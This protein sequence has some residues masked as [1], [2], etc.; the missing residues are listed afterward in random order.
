MGGLY[1]G[2]ALITIATAFLNKCLG[3]V[4]EEPP[5]GRHT[6]TSSPG[7]TPNAFADAAATSFDLLQGQ[8]E[9]KDIGVTMGV[10]RG[11]KATSAGA[12]GGDR[13]GTGRLGRVR[14]SGVRLG[15]RRRLAGN[16]K[17]AAQVLTVE[18]NVYGNL[19]SS[20]DN[21]S[22]IDVMEMFAGAAE[23]THRAPSFGLK[24]LQPFDFEYGLDLSLEE[25]QQTWAPKKV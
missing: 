2:L 23:I 14:P 1:S 21:K 11:D 25:H 24:S 15:E 10:A 7:T 22:K 12:T 16:L 5:A 9:A 4:L 3:F 17:Q 8:A 20:M 6:T 13:D 18:Q 19:P